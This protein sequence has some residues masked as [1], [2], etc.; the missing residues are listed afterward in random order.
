MREK[1]FNPQSFLNIHSSFWLSSF[2]AGVFFAIGYGISKNIYLSKI[3][4]EENFNHLQKSKENHDSKNT[5]NQEHHKKSNIENK[6]IPVKD[7]EIKKYIFLPSHKDSKV[8]LVIK[9]S[10]V[11]NLENQ[12]VFKNN[13]NFFAKETVR[14]LIKNLK[15]TKKT[16]SSKVEAD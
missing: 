11:E 16:K 8:R 4:T 1:N 10:Q 2:L 5:F 3:H 15:S 12:E 13:Q 14:S 7:K 6:N 9:Y